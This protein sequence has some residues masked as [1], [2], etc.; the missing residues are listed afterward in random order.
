MGDNLDIE[1]EILTRSNTELPAGVPLLKIYTDFMVYLLKHTRD[2]FESRIIEGPKVW[3]EHHQDM[4]VV[5]AHP[6]GWG[7]KEQNF[8]RQAAIAA[9]YVPSS[10]AISQIRFVSEAEASVH[11]CMFHSD[12]HNRLKVRVQTC[13]PSGSSR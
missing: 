2:F 5:L 12:L 3:S 8:L 10:K 13:T 11:F 1:H 7:V 9:N 4:I 6:N